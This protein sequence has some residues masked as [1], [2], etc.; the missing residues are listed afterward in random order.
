MASRL[1]HYL[2]A[3]ELA[4]RQEIKDKNRFCIG[5]LLPD[6]SGH[7]DGSYNTAHFWVQLE[8]E[9]KKGINWLLFRERY[10]E[11]MEKD[12]L[13]LG[14]YCHLI[15]DSIWFCTIVDKYIRNYPLE[16]KKARYDAG[17]RDYQR[18]N[19]LLGKKYNLCY[20]IYTISVD[21]INE[22]KGALLENFLGALKDDIQCASEAKEDELEIYKLDL[23]E[24]YINK[25]V[26]MC[27]S[28]I[29]AFFQGEEKEQPENY[30]V[31]I[32]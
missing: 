27:E 1:L 17:Y 20:N 31:N 24:E 13:Y 2:I 26:A 3:S 23:M 4:E 22:V 15:M 25:S 6:L 9:N 16:I 18:L 14:Y 29:A 30:Y 19:Y 10:A 7:E 32:M 8:K 21:E 5:A 12:S 28:E 11:Q